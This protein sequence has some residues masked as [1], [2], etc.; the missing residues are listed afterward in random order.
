[1]GGESLLL[2]ATVHKR[3]P[4]SPPSL[5]M[6]LKNWRKTTYHKS[7]WVTFLLQMAS[8]EAAVS[9][10]NVLC[11]HIV[12]VFI[13]DLIYSSIDSQVHEQSLL[14][15]RHQQI[16]VYSLLNYFS[17]I[18]VLELTFSSIGDGNWD[19]CYWFNGTGVEQKVTHALIILVLL[20]VLRQCSLIIRE[21]L[22]QQEQNHTQTTKETKAGNAIKYVWQS[23]GK[24]PW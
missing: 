11:M 24:A 3:G 10:A 17:V 22:N 4:D 19:S 9:P 5:A 14:N 7:S 2:Q 16:W 12:Q 13:A 18:I 21:M 1:M 8:L 15:Q 23:Y 20:Q 6:L